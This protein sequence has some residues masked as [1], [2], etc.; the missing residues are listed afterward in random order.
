MAVIQE[1]LRLYP[2]VIFIPKVATQDAFVP[3]HTVPADGSGPV[4]HQVFVPK[5]TRS[6]IFVSALHYNR[7][8]AVV[9]RCG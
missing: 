9:L 2:S 4:R 3:A 7:E 1:T 8:S 5:G 6:G